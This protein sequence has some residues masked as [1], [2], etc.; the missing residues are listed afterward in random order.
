MPVFVRIKFFIL[1]GATEISILIG[2]ANYMDQIRH[3]PDAKLYT[4]LRIYYRT[5]MYSIRRCKA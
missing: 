5:Y 2:Q 1:E 3:G 4:M